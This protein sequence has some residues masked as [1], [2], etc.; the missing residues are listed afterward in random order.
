MSS[1][2]T[3]LNAE[4]T[5]ALFNILT[6][7]ETYN[8][9]EGFKQPETVSNYGYPFA[10]VPPKAG[11][12]VVYAPESTSPLLQSLFTRFVL[13]VPGVS[14]FTPEFWNVRVQGILKKFAEVDLSESYEKGALGIRKTL[15]TASSTVIETVARGQIGGGPVSDSAKRSINY[16]LNKAEDLSRAWD[17]SM[18]DLVY[19]DFCDE[20]LDHLA[21]TDD[22]QSHSPQ[23][24]AACDYIL[25]HLATLCHQV[26]IVSPEGQYLVKLM[27]NVHKMVPYAMVRQT[28]RIGNAAT[29]IAGMMKIFLAKI[30]VGSVS[31]WF[32]LTSNAADGQ[33]L[34]QKIITVI[35]GWDC[36]DFKKTIDKIAK[37][38]DGP[39]KGALEAIRA[40]TQAPKSVRDAIRDKSVHESKSVIAVI[41]KAANPVLLEDLREN[42][43]QQC[44]DYYA[45]L[46]AIRDREEIISVLCKQTP[47]LLTQAIR[48]AVAGMDPIIRAVHNKVDL[49]DHVKDYQSFLDQLIAT[50][51]P[52][53]TKS[54]DDAESLP[55][56]EDYVL[57]LKNNRHLLY[58]WLHAVSKNCPEVMDQFRK[59]AKDSLVAFHKKKNGESI[60][61]KLGGLFS[62]IPEETE[63]K[64]IP[65]IDDHAAYLRKL[66]HLSHAR[67]Q[68]ILDGGSST[69]SG[70]GVYLIRWQSMLDETYITPATPSGPVRRGKNLQEADSQGKRGSTSSGD[71][72]EA[73]TKMRSMTLSSV[74]DAP[75][76]AP[77]IE[78]LGPKFKQMLV[79]TSAH[80]SNGNA[81]LK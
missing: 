71:V 76:V 81:S 44:L 49:S 15:A 27:D 26:L 70:P 52:K 19:G 33:N 80:R 74:P 65:I 1:S 53:K 22:F 51:K 45:A 38:K 16:D 35:L 40:H 48:D 34:L 58:K 10:A 21:K 14:S 50:S 4:Q 54:K 73:I 60:E 6:H 62:Q 59:W 39:S 42:E 72:G 11:E 20:L 31:N 47:D 13:A 3:P 5:S 28:L 75:D 77:V 2:S 23:V 25:V 61:T 32:G 56:V 29:M 24:A 46:L 78:A 43:H 9:I 41:L 18:T 69:M 68:T 63:A 8:E 12:A 7:F 66:D 37:A 57:L 55:T 64:L 30:S 79:A 17:D 67:M 36:A